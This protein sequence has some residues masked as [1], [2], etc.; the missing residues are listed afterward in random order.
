MFK[1]KTSS[2]LSNEAHTTKAGLVPVLK[3]PEQELG[4]FFWDLET[5][6]YLDS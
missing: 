5:L 6:Q 4:L 3:F 2:F 1:I